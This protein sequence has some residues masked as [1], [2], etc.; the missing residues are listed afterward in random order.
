MTDVMQQDKV[1]MT[2]AIATFKD[3]GYT[4]GPLSAGFLIPVLGI[5]DTFLVAGGAFLLLIPI[6]LR[7]R[8]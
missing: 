6:A 5:H 1:A 3:L 8:D 4:L 7:L 2:G